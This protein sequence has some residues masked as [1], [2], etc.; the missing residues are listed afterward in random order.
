M[1]DF[2]INLRFFD[3][4]AANSP[5]GTPEAVKEE[6]A[7]GAP[8]DSVQTDGT[9]GT[10]AEDYSAFDRRSP[11]LM[12]GRSDEGDGYGGEAPEET[13]RDGIETAQTEQQTAKPYKVLKYHGQEVPVGSE[14]ELVGLAQQ[15]LDYTRKTQRL[16]PYRGFIEKLERDPA[17]MARVVGLMNGNA[18]QSAPDAARA[19]APRAREAEPEPRDN[20]TWDEYLARREAWNSK[21]GAEG[22][23]ADETP[24]DDAAERQRDFDRRFNAAM[25]SRE[26]QAAAAMTAQMTLRDPRH[27]DVLNAIYTDVPP[28]VREA[29]NRDITSYQT[30]YDQVRRNLTGEA[31]FASGAWRNPQPQQQRGEVVLK[32]GSK[33]AP[34]VESGRGQRGPDSR[35]ARGGPDIWSMDDAAFAR[36]MENSMN[37]R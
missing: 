14:E 13:A 31:Y 9:A 35:Q 26:M 32:S 8:A 16:A 29:M 6:E 22:R 5:E 28:A 15:G 10:D 2:I 7:G 3:G 11:L 23:P 1:A 33:P 4:D 21:Q 27:L 20:E 12:Q 18:E 25:E 37:Q 36:L 17:L 19:S 24:A 34:V 30:V